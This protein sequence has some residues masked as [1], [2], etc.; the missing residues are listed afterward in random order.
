MKDKI[1]KNLIDE[2][3]IIS[4]ISL[5]ILSQQYISAVLCGEFSE[6]VM[7]YLIRKYTKQEVEKTHNLS[8]LLSTLNKIPNKRVSK[9]IH[10]ITYKLPH[11]TAFKLKSFLY[12]SFRYN[13]VSKSN[14]K[15][16]KDVYQVCL[17]LYISLIC[18]NPRGI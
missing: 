12:T 13:E 7:K 15:A 2:Y 18:D 10:S 14:L 16:L 1:T 6:V 4:N 8:S 17:E 9:N 5:N 11:K 3:F